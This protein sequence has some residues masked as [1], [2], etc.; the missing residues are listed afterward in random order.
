[1]STAAQSDPIA[2]ISTRDPAPD[3]PA[4]TGIIPF[5][6]GSI[7]AKLFKVSGVDV[8]RSGHLFPF[9]PRDLTPGPFIFI[10]CSND[11]VVPISLSIPTISP[12][13]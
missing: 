5:K 1:M 7:A 8:V 11:I 6:V 12:S 3:L 10:S 2:A 9:I 4:D 13:L